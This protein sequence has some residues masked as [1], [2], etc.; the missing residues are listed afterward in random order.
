MTMHSNGTEHGDYSTREVKYDAANPGAV[1]MVTRAVF[2]KSVTQYFETNGDC[3][4]GIC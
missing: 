4:Y 2:M 3:F 1:T